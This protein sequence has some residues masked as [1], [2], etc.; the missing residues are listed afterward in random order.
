MTIFESP[1][2]DVAIPSM[3]LTRFILEDVSRY[4]D[5]PAMIDGPSGRTLSLP[6]LA[7]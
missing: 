2:K 1:H 4:G 6:C 7:P 5:K 3:P